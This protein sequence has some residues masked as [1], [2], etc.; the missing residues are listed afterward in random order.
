MEKRLRN[1]YPGTRSF[2]EHEEYLFFGRKQEA[3]KL[4]SL[5]KSQSL[6]VLF[7]KSGIGKSSILNAGL[8]PMLDRGLYLPI[9]IRM[10]SGD[11]MGPIE[12]IKSSLMEYLNE[13]K[14]RTLSRNNFETAP[15]WEFVRSCEFPKA[16]QEVIPILIFDQFEEFFDHKEED[17]EF[18]TAGLADLV[19]ER[20]PGRIQNQLLNI[21]RRQRTQEQLDWHSPL[22]IKLMFAIRSDRL[23]LMDQ[24]SKQIPTILHNRFHL[25]P[26]SLEQ[27][28]DA[29]V[30]PARMVGPEFETPPFEYDPNTLGII[31]NYLKDKNNE[32]ESFQLQLICQQIEKEVKERHG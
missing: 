27:A 5:I 32:I 26:L 18:A 15:L 29:M 1:R 16:E 20:L 3:R 4:L 6:V 24:M 17:Q 12:L 23:S 14:L 19:N 25:K 28:K 30:E 22:T 7:S 9:K 10:Q 8:N 21:P 2:Q 13:N 11:K 31:L